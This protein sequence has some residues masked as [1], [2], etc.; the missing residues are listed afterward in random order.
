MNDY[1]K[2][3]TELEE[4]WKKIPVKK[5][6]NDYEISNYGLVR[7]SSD[8]KIIKRNIKSGYPS[9]MYTN[10]ENNKKSLKSIKIHKMVAKLFVENDDPENNN[11]VNHINGDKLDCRSINLEWTT[12]QG[13]SQ[14]A[15]DNDL[16]KKTVKAVIKYNLETGKN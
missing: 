14:H 11:V 7:R 8:K 1:I 10:L 13:N 16:T 4:K 15:I 12:N 3:M 5:I 9:F 2:N 6:K